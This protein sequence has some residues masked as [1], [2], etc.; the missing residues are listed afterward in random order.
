MNKGKKSLVAIKDNLSKEKDINNKSLKDDNKNN[1]NSDLKDKE[2][3]EKKLAHKPS[4]DQ[5]G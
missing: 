3:K 5:E 2:E 4:L 1:S